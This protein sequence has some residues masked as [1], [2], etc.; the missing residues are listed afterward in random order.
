MGAAA[1]AVIGYMIAGFIFDLFNNETRRM[2]FM[3]VDAFILKG[4]RVGN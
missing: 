1:A 3:K 2:F 4:I